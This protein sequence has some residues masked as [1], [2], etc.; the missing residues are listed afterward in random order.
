MFYIEFKILL[1]IILII[2]I[3]MKKFLLLLIAPLLLC[4]FTVKSK[5]NNLTTLNTQ[6]EDYEFFVNPPAF[7]GAEGFGKLATGGRGGQVIYVTNLN[8]SGTG[9]LRA[10][11]EA[12]GAR[13]VVFKVSGIISLTK[14]LKIDNGNIT[15]A[16]QSAPGDGICLKNYSVSVNADNVIIRFM[17]FRMGDEA[18]HEGDAIGGRFKNNII[19]DHCSMSWSTDE[20]VSFYNNQNTTVQWCVIAESLRNSV[21]GKGAHGYGGIWGGKNASFHHNLLAHHDSRNARL[22]EY[23]GSSFALTDLVDIRNNVIYN[24]GHNSAYGGEAMNANFINNYY[25]PGPSTKANNGSTKQGRIFSIDKNKVKGTLV[26]D[27]W[28]KF[29]I[30]GNYVDG[31]SNATN[32]NWTYGV[33]NQYHGSYSTYP[34]SCKDSNGATITCEYTI[35]ISNADKVDMKLNTPLDV[36]NNVTTHSAVEAY[37]KVLAYVGASLVR[38]AVDTRIIT[39]TENGTYTYTG[40]NGSTNGIIDTQSDVG[41]WPTYNTAAA[42]IDT[43]ND[44]MP[45]TWEDTN[46]LN[47]NSASDGAST[48]LDGSYT[49]VEV[50]LNSLVSSII[51]SQNENALSVQNNKIDHS[52]IKIYPVPFQNQFYIN[53]GKAEKVEQISVYNVLG[54]QI[55]LI[56]TNEIKS[57]TLKIDI[58]DKTGNLFIVKIVTENGV[59]N[60]TIIKK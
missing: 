39:E 15:I 40:S 30:D 37:N 18:Q 28:G 31:N 27:I 57:Q 1:N 48:S 17:R 8:D 60:R 44:G 35:P 50:Y 13:I 4:A 2:Q 14:D 55:R 21:H 25:K 34:S 10:A 5:T 42:P 22:G 36:A 29:Y 51:S 52:E 59:I 11:V 3:T 19:I 45:D 24:W 32:D 16:G 54:K 6:L 56:K 23:A 53:F 38:D 26:Y 49:N 47:K 12:S 7:P 41:G 58:N 20:C 46:G 33:Y 43:D 9:S